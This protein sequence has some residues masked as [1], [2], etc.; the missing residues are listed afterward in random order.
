MNITSKLTLTISLGVV[1]LTL[2]ALGAD[3]PAASVWEPSPLAKLKEGNARF[4]ESTVSSGKPTAAKRAGNP[5]KA[6]IRLRSSLRVPIRGRL[7]KSSS[8]KTLA[9]CL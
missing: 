8:I 4:V 3:H 6:S 7:Q 2:F 5:R 9:I 1:S